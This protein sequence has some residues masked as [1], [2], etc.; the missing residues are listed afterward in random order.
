[1]ISETS[2]SGLLL[3]LL[4]LYCPKVYQDIPWDGA[5]TSVCSSV[6]CPPLL[7]QS[8]TSRSA[9]GSSC[10]RWEGLV[11]AVFRSK[12]KAWHTWP[13]IHFPSSMPMQES[14]IQ[15][16]KLT[17]WGGTPFWVWQPN[18]LCCRVWNVII[19]VL[20]C[21]VRVCMVLVDNIF[22]LP[23]SDFSCGICLGVL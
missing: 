21:L 7:N 19:P 8:C 14:K 9:S 13:A 6:A 1:M 2:L 18:S 11:P 10:W 4:H 12:V 22:F 5:Q 20:P 15:M 16:V 3:S 17:P 23:F